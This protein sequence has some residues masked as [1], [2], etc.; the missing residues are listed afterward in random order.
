MRTAIATWRGN[1]IDLDIVCDDKR[2]AVEQRVEELRLAVRER[3][4]AAKHLEYLIE[5]HDE[6]EAV[7]EWFGPEIAAQFVVSLQGSAL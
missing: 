6:R 1:L 2:Q 3:D 7:A 4:R 5:M